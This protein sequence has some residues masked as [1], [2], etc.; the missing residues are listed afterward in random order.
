MHAASE[1]GQ[2]TKGWKETKSDVPMVDRII[3]T[4][5]EKRGHDESA[6]LWPIELDNKDGHTWLIRLIN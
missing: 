3:A 4:K 6:K 5:A 1:C 2:L